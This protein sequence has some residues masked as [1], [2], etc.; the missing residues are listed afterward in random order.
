MADYMPAMYIKFFSKVF[1]Q[2]P[3]L[4]L[5]MDRLEFHKDL[6]RYISKRR[7][8]NPLK[9]VQGLYD[10]KQ[11]PIQN[12]APEVNK[13]DEIAQESTQ[14]TNAQEELAKEYETERKGFLGRMMEKWFGAR[15]EIPQEENSDQQISQIVEKDAL[16]SDIRVVAKIALQLSK[17]V[18][19]EQL[20]EF[21][22]SNDFILFKDILRKHGLIK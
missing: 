8:Q 13:M 4:V 19:P 14:Q 10:K 21:K 9:A 11:Q 3:F 5:F 12:Y 16:T 2:K 6:G 17:Q 7:K 20:H 15:E 18:P 1:K 22:E